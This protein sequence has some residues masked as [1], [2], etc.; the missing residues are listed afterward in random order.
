MKKF[1]PAFDFYP[2]RFWFAVEGW[3]D[4]EIVRYWRLLGQ[5]WMR[6]GLPADTAALQELARGKITDRVLQKFPESAD[7]LRRNAFLEKLRA[8]QM[9]RMA[10]SRFKNTR[11]AWGRN[12]P[13]QPLPAHLQ[14]RKAFEE[15]LQLPEEERLTTA[16]GAPQAH[17]RRTTGEDKTPPP[18]GAPTTH[19]SPL[20]THPDLSKAT[21]PARGEGGW[22]TIE[23][24]VRY[25]ETVM[26]PRECCEKFWNEKDS[27][28]WLSKHGHPLADWRGIFRNYVTA[29]KANEHKTK[30]QHG[31]GAAA[32]PPPKTPRTF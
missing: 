3:T 21:Q 28:G 1:S 31:K 10:V 29:W 14:S 4:S 22:P 16:T 19:H 5:Q 15:W 25:G 20:T 12:H 13:G 32:V 30:L 27:E 26:A 23:E 18:L 7:G 24:V 2:E 8:E 11:A 17:H 9:E 6:D